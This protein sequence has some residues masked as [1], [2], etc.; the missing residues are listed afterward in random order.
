MGNY[1][2]PGKPSKLVQNEKRKLGLLAAQPCPAALGGP[3]CAIWV[4]LLLCW[5]NSCTIIYLIWILNLLTCPKYQY[6]WHLWCHISPHENKCIA[7]KIQNVCIPPSLLCATGGTRSTLTA[8]SVLSH[9]HWPHTWWAPPGRSEGGADS[10][11]HS[12]WQRRADCH[13][14]TKWMTAVCDWCHEGKDGAL[15]MCKGCLISFIH[16]FFKCLTAPA[17]WALW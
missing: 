4:S 14:S 9:R 12:V 1:R 7:L 13:S 3:G 11:Q 5:S 8:A 17:C 10:K 15:S 6:P 2:L 16:S